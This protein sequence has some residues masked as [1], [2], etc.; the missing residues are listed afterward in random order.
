MSDEVRIVAANEASWHDL[1][2]VLGSGGDP[3]RCQCQRYK[4]KPG[5]SWRSVGKDELAFRFRTQTHCGHPS[6]ETTSGLVAYLDGE[7]VGWCAVEP[8]TNYPRLLLKTRVPW[9]GRSEDKTDDSVWAVTCF[10]TPPAFGSDASVGRS[11][12]PPSTSPGTAAPGL[13]RAIR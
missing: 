6:S 2:T 5:E 12:A 4:M 11:C 9:E 13:S 10:V 1:Q 3:R 7:P 8:R